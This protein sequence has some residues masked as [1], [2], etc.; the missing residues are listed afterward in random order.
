MRRYK[1]HKDEKDAPYQ[2]LLERM[3]ETSKTLPNKKKIN[4]QKNAVKL[5]T[6]NLRA[7][8]DIYGDDDFG[9][10]IPMAKR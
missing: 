4:R 5:S 6:V 7:R 3:N 10:Q 8:E 1:E 9:F 2:P